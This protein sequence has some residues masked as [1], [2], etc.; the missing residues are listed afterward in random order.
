MIVVDRR[1]LEG[2]NPGSMDVDS[3]YR[4][5]GR[6]PSNFQHEILQD[7]ATLAL[8]SLSAAHV[9]C[10][11]KEG[12][13]YREAGQ[14]NG[15]VADCSNRREA[16]D[17][18]HEANSYELALVFGRYESAQH[19]EGDVGVAEAE[20][21]VDNGAEG[22]EERYRSSWHASATDRH[23]SLGQVPA[24]YLRLLCARQ[25]EQQGTTRFVG[26][27][28]GL[29]LAITTPYSSCLTCLVQVDLKYTEFPVFFKVTDVTDRLLI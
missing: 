26:V 3:G 4:L 5:S 20:E 8:R 16:V 6:M 10:S 2:L 23:A 22:K 12:D 11:E 13:D 29:R 14:K 24:A 17:G 1:L 7:D 9:R 19:R 18:G 27:I 28:S 15:L 25:T 21:T